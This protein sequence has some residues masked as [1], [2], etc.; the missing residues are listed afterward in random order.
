M[1][2]YLKSIL[3]GVF[4]LLLSIVLSPFIVLPI[5]SYGFRKQMP[6]GGIGW[7]PVSLVK[8][9]PVAWLIL[10]FAFSVGFAWKYIRLTR[11][12]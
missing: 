4:T 6:Q 7:D 11:A 10:A 2:L 3:A 1:T 5:L 9:S 12:H 8:H